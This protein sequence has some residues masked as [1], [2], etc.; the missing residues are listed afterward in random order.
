MQNEGIGCSPVPFLMLSLMGMV[1]DGFLR[2]YGGFEVGT[3]LWH[4]CG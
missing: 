2:S 4:A 3:G 1:D